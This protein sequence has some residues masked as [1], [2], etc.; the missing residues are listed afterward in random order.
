MSMC[1]SPE[2][3]RC[4][5][6]ISHD[7]PPMSFSEKFSLCHKHLKEDERFKEIYKALVSGR[8]NRQ[9]GNTVESDGWTLSKN[10]KTW[11][12]SHRLRCSKCDRTD[13]LWSDRFWVSDDGP[14]PGGEWEMKYVCDGHLNRVKQSKYNRFTPDE[15]TWTKKRR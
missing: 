9:D 11:K 4:I 7:N 10:L 1:V 8:F 2:C 3:K 15:S 6:T 5:W 12:K 13:R 14:Y